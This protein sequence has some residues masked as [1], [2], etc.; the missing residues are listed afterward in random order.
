M[1]REV[2]DGFR[3]HGGEIGTAVTRSVKQN[4]LAPA[5]TG[6]GLAWLMFGRSPDDPA[7][8]IRRH[9][10]PGVTQRRALAAARISK[11]PI[12]STPL[13]D[14]PPTTAMTAHRRPMTR[15]AQ[16]WIAASVAVSVYVKNFARYNETFGTLAG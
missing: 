5:V 12:P 10:G 14:T 1:V 6:E 2:T 4:P 7:E 16:G 9:G 13:A 3:R 8:P 15:V 11:P